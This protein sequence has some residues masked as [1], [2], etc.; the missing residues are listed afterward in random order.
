MKIRRSAAPDASAGPYGRHRCL[1][2]SNSRLHEPKIWLDDHISSV[3]LHG[4]SKNST[5]QCLQLQ[6]KGATRAWL[7]N[8]PSGSIRSWEELVY[9]FICNFKGNCKRA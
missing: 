5:M 2:A 9:R 4:G 3:K 8:L 1:K 7:N 6:L